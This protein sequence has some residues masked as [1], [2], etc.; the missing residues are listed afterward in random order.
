MEK[1][2]NKLDSN[3]IYAWLLSSV[4]AAAYPCS[5]TEVKHV[6]QVLAAMQT[7]GETGKNWFQGTAD[8]VRQF[9]WVFEVINNGYIFRFSNTNFEVDE[10]S[11]PHHSYLNWGLIDCYFDFQDARNRNIENVLILCGDHLYRMDYMDFVQ[12]YTV[13]FLIQFS[14]TLLETS[15]NR[16]LWLFSQSH[17]D[18]NADITISCAAVGQRFVFSFYHVVLLLSLSWFLPIMSC[19]SI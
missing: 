15:S 10:L 9:I 2:I 6:F 5:T 4:I 1:P 8:A 16:C 11:Q 14:C 19:E 12:V 7:P 17:V 18:R 3:E 13:S